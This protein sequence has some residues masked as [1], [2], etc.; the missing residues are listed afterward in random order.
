MYIQI[1]IFFCRV[2]V[3]KL[4]ALVL[5]L[6]KL[7][8]CPLYYFLLSITLL[9][10]ASKL[11]KSKVKNIT[12]T[13]YNIWG[14]GFELLLLKVSSLNIWANK[15]KFEWKYIWVKE[16]VST[17]ERIFEHMFGHLCLREHLCANE[18]LCLNECFCLS[19]CLSEHLSKHVC[20][21]L[22]LNEFLSQHLCGHVFEK[23]FVWAFV[24]VS[25]SKWTSV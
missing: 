23:T 1:C 16:F 4:K 19:E 22:Y 12:Q 25:M 6:F 14:L 18:H 7:E 15:Q 13:F 5:R 17:S 10:I 21:H 3:F 2:R 8:P 11:F 20:E 9:S 24:W